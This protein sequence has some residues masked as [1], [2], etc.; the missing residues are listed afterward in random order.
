MLKIIFESENSKSIFSFSNENCD[1]FYN[2]LFEDSSH[3]QTFIIIPPDKDI[4]Q[5][6]DIYKRNMKS[7][8]ISKD[9]ILFVYNASFINININQNK[10]ISEVFQNGSK[11]TVIDKN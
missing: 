4:R 5:L 2:I 8:D 10:K 7:K 3:F 9:E 6:F 1:C 11:L